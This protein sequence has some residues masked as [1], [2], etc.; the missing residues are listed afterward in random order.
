M[1]ASEPAV[2]T[3]RKRKINRKHTWKLVMVT[4]E[5]KQKPV[6][7]IVKPLCKFSNYNIRTII[8]FSVF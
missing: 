1:F 5:K 2:E 7:K 4:I 3:S 6:T 8:I